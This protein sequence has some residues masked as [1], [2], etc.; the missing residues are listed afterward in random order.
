MQT[1]RHLPEM[2]RRDDIVKNGLVLVKR[3][4]FAAVTCRSVAKECGCSYRTV[5]RLFKN[6]LELSRAV[7]DYARISKDQSI[8]REGRRLGI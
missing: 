5:Q 6:R 8:M 7:L 2:L 4:G 1:R 3:D